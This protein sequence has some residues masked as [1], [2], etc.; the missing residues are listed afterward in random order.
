MTMAATRRETYLLMLKRVQ[1]K[2]EMRKIHTNRLVDD[3][4]SNSRRRPHSIAELRERERKGRK[5]A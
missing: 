4:D 5:K 3:G 1:L 2:H